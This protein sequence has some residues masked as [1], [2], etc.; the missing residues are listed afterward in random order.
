M[1]PTFRTATAANWYGG[2]VQNVPVLVEALRR[3]RLSRTP[4]SNRRQESH[5]AGQSLDR[6]AFRRRDGLRAPAEAVGRGAHLR[7]VWSVQTNRKILGVFEPKG[8]RLPKPRLHQANDEE[9]MQSSMK[10][11]DRL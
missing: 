4:V 2:L 10:Y 9:A 6:K 7:V 3:R 11:S 5:E 8:L 1:P